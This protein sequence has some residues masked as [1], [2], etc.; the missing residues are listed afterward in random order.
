MVE[1]KRNLP[2]VQMGKVMEKV[3]R[4]RDLM[5]MGDSVQAESELI[6]GFGEYLALIREWGIDYSVNG[7]VVAEAK[8][9]GQRYAGDLLSYI[10]QELLGYMKTLESC[11]TQIHNVTD[12]LFVE[13]KTEVKAEVKGKADGKK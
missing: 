1:E 13:T 10:K 5:S 9:L 6:A 2:V 8:A 4:S 12:K 11:H 3:A 7:K